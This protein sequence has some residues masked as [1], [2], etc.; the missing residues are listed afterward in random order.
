MR[1]KYIAIHISGHIQ[2]VWGSIPSATIDSHIRVWRHLPNILNPLSLENN[3]LSQLSET[4]SCK[5][6]STQN[7]ELWFAPIKK[8]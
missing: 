2:S 6:S 7:L 4:K 1:K 8:C 3:L 5:V